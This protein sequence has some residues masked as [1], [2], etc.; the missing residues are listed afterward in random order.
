MAKTTDVT[1]RRRGNGTNPSTETGEPARSPV[2][3]QASASRRPLRVRLV[4]V[5]L[6]LHV[7]ADD[8][9]N[10]HPLQVAPLEVDALSWPTFRLDEHLADLQREVDA[11]V[12]R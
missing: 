3:E 2:L 5:A 4:T 7:V 9:V 11:Q 8:G 1:E 10:L 12:A 6:H